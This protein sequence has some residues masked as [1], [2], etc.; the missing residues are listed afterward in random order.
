M[1]EPITD[2]HIVAVLRPF[3]RAARPV[4]A[5]L[6]DADPFGL[7]GRVLDR[8]GAVRAPGSTAWA[9][10]DVEDRTHWWI[11][12][13]G[14]FTT[15]V[16]A[17]P[18]LGGALAE[19]LQLRAALGAV[20]QGL[21]LCAIAGEHDVRGEDELVALLGA[22]LFKRDLTGPVRDGP[23]EAEV[24]AEARELTGELAVQRKPGL[25]TVGSAVWRLA[26]ALYAVGDELDKRP[27]GRFYHRAVGMLPVIGLAGSYFGE[28][29]GLRRAAK[30]GRRWLRQHQVPGGEPGGG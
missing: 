16:A 18:G 22:V 20:G 30:A 12:R 2:G 13:L 7:R 17:V 10:M 9:G 26:R 25:R 6:R 11:H 21:L 4:L 3:V 23:S 15:L 5:A 29:S 14:R 24:A 27:R 8:L 1:P 28:W 19:R